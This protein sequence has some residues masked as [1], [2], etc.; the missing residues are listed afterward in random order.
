MMICVV[1]FAAVTGLESRVNMVNL[2]LILDD[3]YEMVMDYYHL[4]V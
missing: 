1:M 3:R 4:V 2:M